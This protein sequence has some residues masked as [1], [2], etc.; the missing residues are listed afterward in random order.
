MAPFAYFE[1][2]I[3]F[4]GAVRSVGYVMVFYPRVYRFSGLGAIYGRM[5]CRVIINLFNL[6]CYQC[7]IDLFRLILIY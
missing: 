2:A 7:Y 4:C 1:E 6:T 5:L 3:R